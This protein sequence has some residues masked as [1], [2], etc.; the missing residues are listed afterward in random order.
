MI[1]LIGTEEAFDIIS[2]PLTIKTFSNLGIEEDYLS[3]I[4]LICKKKKL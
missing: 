2:H 4:K 1:T 3:L